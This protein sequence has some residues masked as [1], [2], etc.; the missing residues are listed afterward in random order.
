MTVAV[1]R[2]G[3]ILGFLVG[4]FATGLW[5]SPSQLVVNKYVYAGCWKSWHLRDVWDKGSQSITR[6]HSNCLSFNL[7]NV[8]KIILD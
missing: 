7:Y 8:V 6:A 3:E 1:Q 2:C 5:S 4:F